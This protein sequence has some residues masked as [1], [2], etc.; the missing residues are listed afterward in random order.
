MNRLRE[1]TKRRKNGGIRAAEALVMNRI[2]AAAVVVSLLSLVACSSATQGNGARPGADGGTSATPGSSS[3]GTGCVANGALSCAG[4]LRCGAAC[5]DNDNACLDA[6]GARADS[7]S[8]PLYDA[9]L[10][11][12]T[13]S[14]CTTTDCVIAECDAPITACKADDAAE[15]TAPATGSS[16]SSG[17][18]TTPPATGSTCLPPCLA[19]LKTMCPPL[20]GACTM[21]E[22]PGVTASYCYA[23]GARMRV[24]LGGSTGSVVG[25]PSRTYDTSYGTD[26]TVT[27]NDASGQLVATLSQAAG[28]HVTV[29]CG[30][31]SYDVDPSSAACASDPHAAGVLRNADTTACTTGACVVG[32]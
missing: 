14:T 17:G 9:V 3:G 26:G 5:A 19:Q 2:A 11:C 1:A 29:A 4:T 27:F 31:Q 8:K 22:N 25:C 10:Q 24:D 20:Q 32:F 18:A 16:G 30:G 13:K 23:N 12:L 28:G 6:C 7:A 21:Q 15:C